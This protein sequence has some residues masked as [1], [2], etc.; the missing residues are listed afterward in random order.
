MAVFKVCVRSIPLY[1]LHLLDFPE[2][3]ICGLG[4]ITCSWLEK[5]VLLWNWNDLGSWS[6][7]TKVFQ[8]QDLLRGQ[9]NLLRRRSEWIPV[10]IPPG[11]IQSGILSY[12]IYHIFSFCFSCLFS[13]MIVWLVVWVLY[14]YICWGLEYTI[15]NTVQSWE[16]AESCSSSSHNFTSSYPC[17]KPGNDYAV[18]LENNVKRSVWPWFEDIKR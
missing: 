8:T 16:V 14:I 15:V 17:L 9:E 2:K 1:I 13:P 7:G 5:I 12:P 4:S 11:K 18:R 10:G 6:L 3:T